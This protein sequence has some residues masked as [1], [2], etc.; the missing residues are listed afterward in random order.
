M[1]SISY[2]LSPFCYT[3]HYLMDDLQFH[4]AIMRK[5]KQNAMEQDQDL[6]NKMLKMMRHNKSHRQFFKLKL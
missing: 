6:L 3:H 2:V 4:N 1:S 5:N